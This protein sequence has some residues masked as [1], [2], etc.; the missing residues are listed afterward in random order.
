MGRY[1]ATTAFAVVAAANALSAAG[2]T[3]TAV[4]EPSRRTAAVAAY[5]LLKVAVVTAFAAL[6]AMRAPSRKP[7]RGA[8]AFGACAVALV[9]LGAMRMPPKEATTSLVFAGDVV[10]L[11]SCL[12]LL[13]SV[14]TLGRCF[15]VLPEVRGLV[16]RGPYRIV[17]HPVYAGELGACAGLL[18]AA[19]RVWN[20]VVASCF[21]AAQ[22]VRM[23]LEENALTEEFPE[24]SAYAA[25][26]PRLVPHLRLNPIRRPNLD[27]GVNRT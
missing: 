10:A 18:L 5:G 2:A 3:A 15:G 21:A 16:T 8:L 14:L 26:T 24:Y 9:G 13:V 7:A 19:P 6:V 17:R 11:V 12:W 23:R 27:T 4:V 1:F 22:L 20:V 25:T